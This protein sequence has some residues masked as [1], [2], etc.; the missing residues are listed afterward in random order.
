MDYERELD[1]KI[2]AI[3]AEFEAED[4]RLDAVYGKYF[5]DCVRVGA[6]IDRAEARRMFVAGAAFGR[7]F[8]NCG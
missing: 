5:D 3:E 2:A 8:A 4:A 1:A 6:G 7:R